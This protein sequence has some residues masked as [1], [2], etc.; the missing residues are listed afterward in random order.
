M[1]DLIQ[2]ILITLAAIVVSVVIFSVFIVVY[3]K[4]ALERNISPVELFR[5]MYEGSFGQAFS[6]ATSLERAAPLILTALCVALPARVGLINI[7]GEGALV[8]GGLVSVCT[9]LILFGS[10]DETIHGVMPHASPLLVQTAMAVSAMVTGG[11]LIAFVGWLRHWRGVNETISSLLVFYIAIAVFNFLVEGP[12]KDP[13]SANKPSTYEIM[14]TLQVGNLIGPDKEPEGEPGA[15]APEGAAEQK[16]EEEPPKTGLM[17]DI[18]EILKQVH[19]GLGLGLIFAVVSY[20]LMY[21]TTF[22]FSARMIGGNVKAAQG[23]GL[24]VGWVIFVTCA[25]AGAAA[26]LAGMVEVARGEH[27]ANAAGLIADYGFTGIL[28]SFMARHHPLGIIPVACLFGGLSASSGLIQR[29]LEVPEA[30]IQV[31]MGIMFVTIL[32]FETFYGRFRIFFPRQ[33]KEAPAP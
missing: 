14:E 18:A 15:E 29:R 26:G 32:A 11:L 4:F 23:S 13:A 3:G 20:I 16:T 2:T 6:I 19:W 24:P 30:S 1:R 12:L 5:N 33:L 8:L 28:V 9:G 22:G 10:N 27:R 7:G 17:N 25:L 21:H 31:F